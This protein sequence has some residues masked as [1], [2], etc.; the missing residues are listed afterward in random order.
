M[1][2]KSPNDP[3]IERRTGNSQF[4]VHRCDEC[5]K[6]FFTKFALLGHKSNDSNHE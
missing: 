2:L 4:G 3:S 1:V 5:G 6:P